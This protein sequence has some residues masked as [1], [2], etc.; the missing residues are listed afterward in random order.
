MNPP[1][2][3]TCYIHLV[4]QPS[5]SPISITFSVIYFPLWFIKSSRSLSR[6]RLF[7]TPWTV[8]HQASPSMGFSKQEYWSGVPVPSPASIKYRSS[9]TNTHRHTHSQHRL[10]NKKR[11]GGKSKE[12]QQRTC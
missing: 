4:V 3:Y 8:A 12:K 7:A 10:E 5:S 11:W 9:H 2:A 6:V 1:H